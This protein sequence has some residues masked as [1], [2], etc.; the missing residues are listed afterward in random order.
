MLNHHSNTA[1]NAASVPAMSGAVTQP[2]P[3]LPAPTGTGLIPGTADDDVLLSN[4]LHLLAN[5][6]SKKV[7]SLFAEDKVRPFCPIL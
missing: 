6:T 1:A 7:Q 4:H 3:G 2:P 5:D